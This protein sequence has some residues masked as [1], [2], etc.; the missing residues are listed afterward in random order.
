MA[1]D[2]AGSGAGTYISCGATNDSAFLSFT[3][4]CWFQLD[5]KVTNND[6]LMSRW[7]ANG[8]KARYL[9]RA[10]DTLTINIVT[11][12]GGAGASNAGTTTLV[13][14]GRWYHGAAVFQSGGASS[15]SV[16]LNGVADTATSIFPGTGTIDTGPAG[17]TYDLRIGADPDSGDYG[18]DGRIAEAAVWTAALSDPEILALGKGVLPSQIRPDA[19]AGYWPLWGVASPE[20]DLE[21]NS[22][23]RYN[24]TVTGSAAANHAPVG[25]LPRSFWL[26]S[27]VIAAPTSN[28]KTIM[29]VFYP[30]NVK[31]IEGL[32]QASTKTVLGLA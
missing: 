26:P 23:T 2:F 18:I 16:Y 9:F 10:A 8:N 22:N 21:P 12:N 6:R 20:P 7:G 15:L 19:C 24:G 11:N 5:A 25:R 13:A 1:R 4:A 32:A 17:G 14:D 31:T 3:V 30:S 28:I 27:S 29:G